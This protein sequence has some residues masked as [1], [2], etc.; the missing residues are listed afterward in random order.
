MSLDPCGGAGAIMPP[1][2]HA[3][4]FCALREARE[5]NRKTGK[6]GN[7][8]EIHA[9]LRMAFGC[10]VWGVRIIWAVPAAQLVSAL[11]QH[12]LLNDSPSAHLGINHPLYP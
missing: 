12:V 9:R 4:A 5:L 7:A 1:C 2:H 11:G 6:I 3:T 10:S 8:R